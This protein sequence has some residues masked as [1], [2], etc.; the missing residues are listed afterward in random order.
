MSHRKK[1]ILLFGY[2]SRDITR[3]WILEKGLTELGYNMQ[4]CRTTVKG[5]LPKYIDLT[6]KFLQCRKEVD[7]ILVTFMGYY[8]MPLAWLLA[9][10]TGKVLVFDALVSLYDT[11][12]DDRKFVSPANPRAWFY[13]LFDWIC[14]VLADIV[15][16]ESPVYLHH[17]VRR[18]HLSGKRFL[19]LPVGCRTDIFHPATQRKTHEEFHVM[20]QGMFIP[21]HGIETI[22]KAAAELQRRGVDDVQFHFVGKGQMYNATV[23]RV[24][25]LGLQNVHFHGFLPELSD[26]AEKLR[27]ADIGLGMFATSIK[28]EL[29]MPHKVYE[30]FASKVPL[31]T[32]ETT[33][34]KTMFK[35]QDIALFVPPRDGHALAEK[36]LLLKEDTV[37]R[38]RLAEKGYAFFLK[39][40][41][42]RSIVQP[43]AAFLDHTL[44]T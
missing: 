13:F 40:F 37:L 27:H 21:V 26:V 20:Y 35:G 23:E 32:A 7:V 4:E 41:Q 38:E 24:Q 30:V 17:I 15:L 33:A 19:V 43:L 18:Y 11:N 16:L 14:Y 42:P 29:C 8:F 10:L 25:S 36:I 9:R 34:T 22:I 2:H 39:H 5:F 28:A 3:N 1:T 6:R 44:K 12:V 31:I